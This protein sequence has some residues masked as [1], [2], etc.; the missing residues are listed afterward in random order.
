MPVPTPTRAVSRRGRQPW[1]SAREALPSRPLRHGAGAERRRAWD[2]TGSGHLPRSA[3]PRTGHGAEQPPPPFPNSPAPS[4][5]EVLPLSRF[6][7]L[8]PL[9]RFA[10]CRSHMPRSHRD[11]RSQSRG[12]AAAEGPGPALPGPQR[13]GGAAGGRSGAQ[14]AGGYRPWG[15]GA[16][17]PLP[18]R[19]A[20][21]GP[22]LSG[23]LPRVQ[24]AFRGL[25]F[26]LMCPS[27]CPAMSN[28][29]EKQGSEVRHCAAPL[30]A[31]WHQ[32]LP[33]IFR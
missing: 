12:E 27:L 13:A 32:P 26:D 23:A 33:P 7:P 4:E 14:P 6:Y 21:Q 29:E 15:G 9:L 31:S 16:A 28:S 20:E 8:T 11:A 2:G 5:E 19:P 22:P 17:V 18:V 25:L 30:K 24:G 10:T 1:R 3:G